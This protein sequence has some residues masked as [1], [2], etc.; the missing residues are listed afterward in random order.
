VRLLVALFVVAQLAG[1]VS[2][3]HAGAQ[4]IANAVTTHDHHQHGHDRGDEGK[5]HHP[6][7]GTG[8]LAAS[9]CALHAYFAGVLPPPIGIG[10]ASLVGQSLAAEPDDQDCGIPPDRLDRPPR[11]GA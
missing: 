3:P 1:V 8:N 7:D 2:S 11:L 6:S 10:T 9:C 5:S 4:P